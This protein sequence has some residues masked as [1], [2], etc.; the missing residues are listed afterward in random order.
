MLTL[1]QLEETTFANMVNKM[2]NSRV[3]RKEEEKKQGTSQNKE[4]K[5]KIKNNER[6]SYDNLRGRKQDLI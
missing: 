3:T 2:E 1:N 5:G 4:L 6:R